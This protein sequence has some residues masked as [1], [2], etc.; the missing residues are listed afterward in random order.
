MS[1]NTPADAILDAVRRLNDLSALIKVV[2]DKMLKADWDADTDQRLRLATLCSD[3]DV[4][5]SMLI[6]TMLKGHL[7]LLFLTDRDSRHAK[8]S[9]LLEES[10]PFLALKKK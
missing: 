1:R 4:S 10:K 7:D 9:E 6:L 3:M 5:S 8:I 2:Q